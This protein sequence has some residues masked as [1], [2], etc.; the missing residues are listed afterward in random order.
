ML[1]ATM[2]SPAM[3]DLPRVWIRYYRNVCV[4]M[5][6]CVCVRTCV[7]LCVGAR[8]R[9]LCL[10]EYVGLVDKPPHLMTAQAVSSDL[11]LSLSLS[12]VN[13]ALSFTGNC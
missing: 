8:K 2:A 4:Y 5:H 13:L 7:C 1:L 6:V 9:E 10:I 12:P 11:P 3:S